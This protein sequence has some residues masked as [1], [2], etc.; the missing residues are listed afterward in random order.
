MKKYT[1]AAYY[2]PQWHHDPQHEKK[3]ELGEWG[4]LKRAVP[5][6]PGHNQPKIPVWGYLD[7]S[8]PKTS[9]I[10][11]DAAADHGIDVFIYD[12]YWDMRGENTGK[13]LQGALEKGFLQAENRN[14][15]KFALMLCNHRELS[16]ERWDKMVDCIIEEYF[17]LKEYWELD[18]KKYFSIYELYTLVKGLG[19]IEETREAIESFRAK[20]AAK[21]YEIHL[22]LVE[23]GLQNHE[24]TGCDEGNTMRL[25]GAD[26]VTSY[27]WIHNVMP[28]AE[29]Y[30]PYNKWRKAIYPYWDKFDKEFKEYY[31]NVSMGWDPS[32]R[33]D[34]EKEYRANLTPGAYFS[35]LISDNTPEEF[36]KGL[37]AC[38]N[39]LDLS[40]S[41][42]KIVTL[43]A[44]NEWTEGGYLEPEKK[45][46]YGYLDA[47]KK[48]FG[49]K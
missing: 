17:P 31:P 13:F 14:K 37:L 15:M 24:I 22:N 38:R 12:W 46:G 36:E 40:Q 27:V 39:F 34:P 8:D 29:V 5:R 30:S 44:W 16:R 47:I 21:G 42:H 26:S 7:E 6:F 41:R 1:V 18:G 48:V 4:Q 3:M 10:Q 32:G 9:K 28:K 11:I 25:F 45:Y 35:T 33:F 43:Y 23:W 19:G 49:E 2:F 20:A